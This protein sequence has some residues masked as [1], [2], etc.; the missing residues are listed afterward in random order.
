LED[1][2]TSLQELISKESTKAGGSDRLASIQLPKGDFAIQLVTIPKNRRV[3]LFSKERV[4]LLFAGKRN[5]PMFVLQENSLLVLR[6]KLEIFYNTN[7]VQEAAKLMVR[8]PESSRVEI[9]ADVKIELFS[10]KQP[11]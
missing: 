2:T 9:S 10:L 4:R 5:R 8:Y 11:D 1:I 7:N 6:E 3:S